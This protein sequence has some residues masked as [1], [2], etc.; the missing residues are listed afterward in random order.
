MS[1]RL[2][3]ISSILILALGAAIVFLIVAPRLPRR[4]DNRTKPVVLL[5]GRDDHGLL[6]QA[7]VPLQ[8]SPDDTTPAAF[9]PNGSFVRVTEERGDWMLV[10]SIAPP[11]RT[12]W[13]NDFFLRNRALRL[14]GGGQVSFVDAL[15]KD[16]QVMIA[17]RPIERPDAKPLWLPATALREVGARDH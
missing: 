15:L 16:G 9:L 6:V 1:R 5:S 2:I 8:R 10:E 12:G 7:E 11:V 17:V 13:I 3:F 4:S 14:D